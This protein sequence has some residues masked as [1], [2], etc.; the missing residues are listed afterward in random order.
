MHPN[1][2]PPFEFSQITDNVFI[3]TNSCCQAH[4]AA[5]LL[6]RGVSPDITLEGETIDHPFAVTSPGGAIIHHP[7]RV[8]TYL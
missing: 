8:E 3:G 4:F 5:Q 2:D 7:L 6:D 1:I